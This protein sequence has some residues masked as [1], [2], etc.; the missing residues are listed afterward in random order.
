MTEDGGPQQVPSPLSVHRVGPS[1]VWADS[2]HFCAETADSANKS[3]RTGV[4]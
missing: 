2:L 4:K 3:H 1:V